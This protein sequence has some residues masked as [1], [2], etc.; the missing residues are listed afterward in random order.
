MIARRH[1]WR[2]L[3]RFVLFPAAAGRLAG[4]RGRPAPGRPPRHTGGPQGRDD[5]ASIVPLLM[6]AH[7]RSAGGDLTATGTSDCG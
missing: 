6:A 3:L 7:Q 5:V 4:R 1:R 2:V